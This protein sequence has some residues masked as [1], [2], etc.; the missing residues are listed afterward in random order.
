LNWTANSSATGPHRGPLPLVHGCEI[1]AVD[2]HLPRR[3]RIERPDKVSTEAMPYGDT[4]WDLL[5]RAR[6]SAAIDLKHPDGVALDAFLVKR[7]AADPARFP[8]L[9]QCQQLFQS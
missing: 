2:Q 8:E 1:L 9:S 3:R 6:L 4:R 7:K 5:S